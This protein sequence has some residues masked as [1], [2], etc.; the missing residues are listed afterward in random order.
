MRTSIVAVGASMDLFFIGLAR[1]GAKAEQRRFVI[2]CLSHVVV[3]ESG[4][5]LAIVSN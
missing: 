5:S 3:I 4:N 2:F 1:F